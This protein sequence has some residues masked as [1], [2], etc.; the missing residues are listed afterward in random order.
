[1]AKWYPISTVPAINRQTHELPRV[2]VYNGHAVFEAR[3]TKDG[4]YYDP[5]YDEWN[6]E[7]ATHWCP[8][9]DPP[10]PT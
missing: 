2:I 8:L 10:E 1:M 6:G 3:A 5:V 9:P 7:G 4:C